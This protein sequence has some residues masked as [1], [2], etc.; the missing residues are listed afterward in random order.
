[1]T[2]QASFVVRDTGGA[3]PSLIGGPLHKLGARLGLVDAAAGRSVAMGIAIGC[4]LWGGIVVFAGVSGTIDTVFALNVV[5]GHVRLLVTIPLFFVCESML[6]PH[7]R[8]LVEG[9]RHAEIVPSAQ[10][11]QFDAMVARFNRGASA[12]WP[13]L[14][15]L[16]LAIVPIVSPVELSMPGS[17]IFSRHAAAGPVGLWY[18]LVCLPVFRFLLLRWIWRLALW[19]LFLWRLS[20]L[21]LHLVPTHPDRCAG[22]GYLPVVQAV[23]AVLLAAA[24]AV[25]AATV[26]EDIIITGATLQQFFGLA[27]VVLLIY[28]AIF[29]LPL[30]AFTPQ[31]RS[32]RARGLQQYMDFASGYVTAFE[33]K[34]VRKPHHKANPLGTP[35]LQSL[36]DL[37]N[38]VRVV[39]DMRFAPIDR[40]LL[41]ILGAGAILPMLPLALFQIPLSELAERAVLM[42]FGG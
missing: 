19:N 12:A 22:L 42:L 17:T 16:I 13:E 37:S 25:I 9:L 29:L 4:I 11:P 39:E 15:C 14:V 41:V 36:A 31:L 18:W 26:A 24:S 20:R 38:S 1:M 8:R 32:A 5:G 35:D 33:E 6:A 2:V 23:F 7:L 3:V 28:A 27:I 34:W 40:T 21:G 30:C 10:R